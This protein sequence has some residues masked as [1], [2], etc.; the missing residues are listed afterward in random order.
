MVSRFVI[1]RPTNCP[2]S[3]N[4]TVVSGW[5]GVRTP[6]DVTV[7]TVTENKPI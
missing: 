1:R 7:I 2:V 5:H 6:E 3:D 4:L